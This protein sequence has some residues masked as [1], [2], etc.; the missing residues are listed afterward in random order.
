M[1]TVAAKGRREAWSARLYLPAYHIKEAARYARVSPRTVTTWHKLRDNGKRTLSAK[2]SGLA[3][4]YLQLIEV[5]TIATLRKRG[6]KLEI[7]RDFRDYVAHALNSQYPFAEHRFKTDGKRLVMDSEQFDRAVKGK[8]IEPARGG[9]LAWREVI[10]EK[11]EEFDYHD[12]LASRWHVAGRDKPIII[13][14]QIAFGAP[15]LRGVTTWILRERFQG[16][17]SLRLLADD[18]DLSTSEVKAALAFEH[19]YVR[20]RAGT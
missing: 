10:G 1:T 3:L 9:Q 17:E 16:G 11:L 19:V 20:R 7:I 5:A 13:D 14:P 12:G 4:S 18:F 8:L 6:V 2:D 15:A